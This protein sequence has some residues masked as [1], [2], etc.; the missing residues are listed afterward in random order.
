MIKKINTRLLCIIEYLLEHDDYLSSEELADILKVS[1][2]TVRDEI[3]KNVDIIESYGLELVSKP[4]YG[5]KIQIVD[6]EAFKHFKGYK[7][8]IKVSIEAESLI[9]QEERIEFLIKHYLYI[10]NY[11]KLEELAEEMFVSR[12]TLALDI[13]EVRNILKMYN[14]DFISKPTLGMK[15]IGTEKDKRICISRYSKIFESDKRFADILNVEGKGY[16][17]NADIIFHI[18]YYKIKVY[19]YKL[20]D[21]S[22][23]NLI[24]HILIAIIRIAEGKMIEMLQEDVNKVNK[25]KEYEI[26]KDISMELENIF[27]ISFS[28][29]EICYLAIHLLGKN[30]YSSDDKDFILNKEIKELMND[31][32]KAIKDKFNLDFNNN[33]NLYRNLSLH[34]YPMISRIRYGLEIHNIMKETIKEQNPYAHEIALCASKIIEQHEGKRVSEDETEF[35][36][37]HFS[38]ALIKLQENALNK[39]IILVCPSGKS[40]AEMLIYMLKQKFQLNDEQINLIPLYELK[41]IN[42]EKYDVIITTS[43]IPFKTKIPFVRVNYLLPKE[44]YLKIKNILKDKYFQ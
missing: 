32:Y 27:D 36:T 6:N 9:T 41:N 44:D 26:A 10:D 28:E 17:K 30:V 15:I 43:S 8:D 34:I 38:L 31:I 39:R 33:L 13:K 20:S 3:K 37:L 21:E 16:D 14:L 40:H 11:L 5:Y 23:Y 22:F 42:Q 7:K 24:N 35:I 29:K 19:N 18:I 12:A 25:L 1:S 4:S 2:R